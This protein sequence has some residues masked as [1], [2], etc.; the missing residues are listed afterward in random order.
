[1][2]IHLSC[3]R[4]YRV[5]HT[6]F[7]ETADNESDRHFNVTICLMI[8]GMVITPFDFNLDSDFL[9]E[10]LLRISYSWQG[11]CKAMNRLIIGD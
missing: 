11:W 2:V 6:F 1:M 3:Y 8:W 4:R 5:V 7:D 9:L 10:L